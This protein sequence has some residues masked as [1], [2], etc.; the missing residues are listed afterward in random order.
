[1]ANKAFENNSSLEEVAKAGN[2][3]LQK[4]DLFTR[5]NV[6]TALQNE[7]VLKVLF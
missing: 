2:V 3:E 4:T 6:P 1:M 7:K 5:E